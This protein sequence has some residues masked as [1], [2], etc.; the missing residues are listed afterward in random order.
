MSNESNNKRIAKNTLVLY[1]RMA[2]LMLIS[3]YTSRVLLDALGIEDYG[4]NN[5]V[6]G[7]V[8]LF[9]IVTSALTSSIGC[10]LTYE[11]YI[12]GIHFCR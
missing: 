12:I 3:L 4:I 10:F 6:G 7:A 2:L 8:G 1:F 5:V 11:F 9:Y